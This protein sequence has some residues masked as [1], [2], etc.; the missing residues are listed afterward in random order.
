MADVCLIL[1]GTY[2]YLTGGVSE[3]VHALVEGLPEVEFAVAHLRDPDTPAGPPAYARLPNLT[4]VVDI[5]LDPERDRVPRGAEETVPGA[6]VHHALATGVA[7]E[8]G[9]R[10]KASRGGPLLL[11]EHG[12]A[13]REAPMGS[14]KCHQGK[15]AV[16]CR[17]EDLRETR[18]RFGALYRALA[19]ETYASANAITTVCPANAAHQRSLGAREPRVIQNAVR[20]VP[21]RAATAGPP[22][23]GFVGRVV[24][25]KD[26]AT[27]L[28][29]CRLVADE[30]PAAEFAVVGPLD[31]DAG[32]AERC[33]AL[34]ADLGLA[35]KV[36]F[37]GET[38]PAEWYARLDVV[39]LTSLSEAQP[40][41]ALE[42]MAAGVPVVATAVG[43][44][45]DLLRG[46]GLLTPARN[47]RA[48]ADAVLALCRRP[49]L[50]TRIVSAGRERA[51]R[52]HAPGRMLAAY[53]ALYEELAA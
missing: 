39:V 20:P 19:R 3:W 50:R 25:I 4:E 26:V 15:P 37:T 28:R 45:P 10:V 11:T 29:A 41:V 8:L 17:G 44:C 22:A 40:L 21:E 48:T 51:E 53:R 34:A 36:S 5:A 42:A 52:L 13:W 14:P 23:I 38:D 27:F 47:P 6:A 12:I 32:Y 35:G 33:V 46:A 16:T 7:G 43:G 30:L 2:P 24:P 1:E 18:E 9:S 31:Q 49:D